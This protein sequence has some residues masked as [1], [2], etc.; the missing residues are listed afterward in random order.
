MAILGIESVVYGV[1]DMALCN[2]FWD[3]YGMVRVAGPDEGSV[4]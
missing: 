4:W 1:E 2:R 3:D